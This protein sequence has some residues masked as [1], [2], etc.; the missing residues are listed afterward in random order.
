MSIISKINKFKKD[1]RKTKD[2]TGSIA[3]GA[4]SIQSLIT[5]RISEDTRIGG[6]QSINN[7]KSNLNTGIA[8]PSR[9][10]VYLTTPPMLAGQNSSYLLFRTSSA[11]L[12]GQTL[13]RINVKPLGYGNPRSL[14]TN[15]NIFPDVTVEFMASSDQREYK[16]FTMWQDGIIKKPNSKAE[17]SLGFH[18]VSFLNRYACKMSIVLY[19]ELGDAVYECYFND[20]YPVQI[21]PVSLSWDANDQVYKFTVTFAYTNWY[22][23]TTRDG[24]DSQFPNVLGGIDSRIGAG[25]SGALETGF[26]VFGK[27]SDVPQGVYDAVNVITGGG[28]LNLG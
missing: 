4:S 10:A 8:K 16:Y 1:A 20:L 14:P 11:E 2:F 27:S 23:I 13:N 26:G 6:L 9:Y 28:L 15:Y 7:I 19:N 5:G 3:Q 18:T 22:D 21:N 17:S 12:P 24:F 25:I